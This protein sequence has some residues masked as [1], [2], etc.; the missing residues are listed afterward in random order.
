M[1]FTSAGYSAIRANTGKN[2]ERS[3][4]PRRIKAPGQRIQ[5]EEISMRLRST[6]MSAIAAMALA[7][8]LGFGLPA[9]N[10]AAGGIHGGAV[11]MRLAVPDVQGDCSLGSQPAIGVHLFN[12]VE[13]GADEWSCACQVDT[14][15]SNFLDP[16]KSVENGCLDR[17]Y[18][19]Q[20][21]GGSSGWSLCIDGGSIRNDIGMHYWYPAS[22]KVGASEQPC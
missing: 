14:V 16:I 20:N 17:I 3:G 10:A 4:W 18:L 1:D 6:I 15:Y 12:K 22:M 8:G 11:T 19:Q 7:F 13:E 2:T 21:Y 5:R 9:A